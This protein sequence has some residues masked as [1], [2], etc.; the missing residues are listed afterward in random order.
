LTP[1]PSV[2]YPAHTFVFVLWLEISRER[3]HYIRSYGFRPSQVGRMRRHDIAAR[4]EQAAWRT[5]PAALLHRQSLLDDER[6]REAVEH[7][8]LEDG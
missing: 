6:I 1:K 7:V 4:R 5:G 3:R 2:D 8:R